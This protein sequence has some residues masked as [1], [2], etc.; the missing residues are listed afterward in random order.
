[1]NHRKMQ[2]VPQRYPFSIWNT[3]IYTFSNTLTYSHPS[4]AEVLAR[5][6]I[7][8]CTQMLI[9]SRT[10]QRERL[11][12]IQRCG[13]E[14]DM[15]SVHDFSDLR[16]IISGSWSLLPLDYLPEL[17]STTCTVSIWFESIWS[18]SSHSKGRQ[19]VNMEVL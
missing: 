1:M 5:R 16:S 18:T 7:D 11:K 3:Q 12:A 10:S 17:G 8:T 4:G 9:I 13:F 6:L 14:N 19:N 15:Q 2:L